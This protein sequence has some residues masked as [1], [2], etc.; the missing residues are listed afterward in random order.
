MQFHL[1]YLLNSMCFF[2]FVFFDR[3]CLPP[4][5]LEWGSPPFWHLAR[6]FLSSPETLWQWRE[7]P[8]EELNPRR[9]AAGWSGGTETAQEVDVFAGETTAHNPCSVFGPHI[10]FLTNILT[11]QFEF[12]LYLVMDDVFMC[13]L[14]WFAFKIRYFDL[15]VCS[16]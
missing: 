15:N 13:D 1:P 3:Q 12:S 10:L 16:I 9:A 8:G 11:S 5:C 7:A 4:G 2:F 6:W 14:F